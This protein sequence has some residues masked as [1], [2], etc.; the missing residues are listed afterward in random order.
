MALYTPQSQRNQRLI[1]LA[2]TAFVL[3]AVLGGF[4]GRLTAPTPADRVVAVREQ[5]RQA[6]SQLGVVSLHIKDGA[7]SL[8]TG[9]NAGAGLALQRADDS[10]TR[11]LDQAPWITD[12]RRNGLLTQVHTLE[13]TAGTGVANASFATN[14]D[15]LATDINTTFGIPT[16]P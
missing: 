9:G 4:T 12:E 3:G 7:K 11:A 10:L 14:V 15:R 16:T 13:R 5:A 6:S 1:I 2:V 8:G